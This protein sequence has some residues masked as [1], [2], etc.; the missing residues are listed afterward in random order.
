M[1]SGDGKNPRKPSLRQRADA[2][3]QHILSDESRSDRFLSVEEG[4]K[5]LHELRVH[6]IQMEM[7]NEELRQMQAAL[8]ES[9]D[10]YLDLYDFAPLGYLT[11]SSEGF[12]EE[13]NLTALTLL[14]AAS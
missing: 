10:S 7:Q 13:I 6:Q 4:K 3:A 1:T 12:I 9:R 5:V 14:G 8:E 2:I 11:L